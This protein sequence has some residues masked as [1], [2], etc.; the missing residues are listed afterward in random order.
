M[1]NGSC[2]D[3]KSGAESA[4][5]LQSWLHPTLG[6]FALAILHGR[7]EEQKARARK[8]SKSASALSGVQTVLG[9]LGKHSSHLTYQHF[10]N[11]NGA[12][13]LSLAMG[14]LRYVIRKQNS[15]TSLR[16]MVLK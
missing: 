4:V 12:C 2:D 10:K 14:T 13:I 3:T 1:L 8:V 15:V 5:G 11:R 16:T 6:S 7:P 9:S